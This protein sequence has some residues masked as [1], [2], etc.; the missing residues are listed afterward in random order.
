MVREYQHFTY[1]DNYSMIDLSGSPDLEQLS[2]AYGI[3]FKRLENMEKCD[4]VI[5]EFLAED[6]SMILECII[7]PMDLVKY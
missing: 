2:K 3:S 1:K 5:D 7:D 4:E 6:T